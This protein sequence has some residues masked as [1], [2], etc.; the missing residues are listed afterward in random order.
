MLK[1]T[2]GRFIQGIQQLQFHLWGAD[3]SLSLS[4]GVGGGLGQKAQGIVKNCSGL[5]FLIVL[6]IS[7]L[8]LQG[9]LKKCLLFK[10]T[11]D[12]R[13]LLLWGVWICVLIWG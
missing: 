6:I 10:E 4:R 1:I 7:A 13:S 11:V 8:V 5:D 3:K 2:E 9:Y 12:V